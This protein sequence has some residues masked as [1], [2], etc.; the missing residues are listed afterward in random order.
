MSTTANMMVKVGADISDFQNKFG[1]LQNGLR[2][3]GESLKRTGKTMTTRVTAPILALGAG[4]V[5]T[6]ANFEKSMNHVAAVSGATGTEFERLR[7]Q[8]KE[9]GNTTMHSAS[10]VADGMGYLAMAGF[11]VN[12]IM[13]AMPGLL[14]LATASGTDLART[15][16]IT[17]N[18]LTG[19]ALDAGEAGRVADVLALAASSA[20][21]DV[22]QL[23]DAMSYVAPVA[24]GAGLSL[25]EV[26]ASVGFMSDASI[27]GS[28]AGTTLRRIISSLQNPVGE[29]VKVL[30]EMGVS[31][32]DVDPSANSLADILR[33]LEAA[34]MDSSQAL[35]LVGDVGGPGL[36]A[37]M[38]QGGD[39]LDEFSEELRNSE[40]AA[41]EMAETMG[42]GM[43]GAYTTLTSALE[44]LAIEFG[45]VLAPAIMKIAG[46]L[47]KVIRWFSELDVGFKQ[48]IVVV[49][50]VVAAI[51]PLLIVIGF[52]MT[53]LAGVT[54][55]MVKVVAIVALVIAAIGGLVAAFMKAWES[56]DEFR[57]AVIEVWENIKETFIVAVDIIKEVLNSLWEFFMEVFEI[58][59][60]YWDEYGEGLINAVRGVFESIYEAIATVIGVIRDFIQTALDVLFSFWE[61]HG[62]TVMGLI[63]T[64]FGAIYETISMIVTNISDFIQKMLGKIT[65]FWDEHGEGIMKIIKFAMTFVGETVA[66]GLN[67]VKDIFEWVWPLVQ[68]IVQSAWDIITSVIGGAF[69]VISGIIGTLIK[70]VTGDFAGA[71]QSF[72]DIFV[73][74]WDSVVGIFKGSINAIISAINFFIRGI[75][76]ISFSPPSWVPGI[77]GKSFG[78]NIPE[79]PRLATGGVASGATLAEIGEGVHPEMVTPLNDA[80][81]NPF[82][83]LIASHMPSNSNS[84]EHDSNYNGPREVIVPIH[85]EG[86][87]IARVTAP[88]MDRELAKNQ[89]GISRARGGG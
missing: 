60:G 51:G 31:L 68:G 21:T 49:L 83:K 1:K 64:V 74:I 57:E 81:M 69:D 5:V 86:R 3:T 84:G 40:G 35:R 82:A 46:A 8:A 20:N 24:Q 16:D 72:K 2:T 63:S 7:D 50:A 39:A 70:L 14:D 37:M 61:K 48:I 77:G 22:A 76:K 42:K 15:A 13:A 6:S 58:I 80:T 28:R 79:I 25:E 87:E 59:K 43:Y 4:A 71:W 29:T 85:L 44:G 62:E 26:S 18:I 65:A 11:E 54:V 88:F 36:I 19:F 55:A 30:D 75:N 41:G 45:E 10:D 12:E 89:R 56:S 66:V 23:G 9:L 52:I 27:Q 38:E 47:T 73:G 67:V 53:A 33:T 32:E 17:S 78:V 34:G